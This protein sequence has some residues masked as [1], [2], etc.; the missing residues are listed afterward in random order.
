MRRSGL[1]LLLVAMAAV[2]PAA[3]AQQGAVASA[4]I[5]LSL[6][7]AMLRVDSSSEAIGIARAAVR[8]AEAGRIRARSAWL[9]QLSGSAGYTRTIKSQF[10]GLT[11]AGADSIPGPTNC[12]RFRPNPSLP[13]AERLDSLERGL[14]CAA[15]SGGSAFANLPFGRKNQWSFALSASQTLFNPQLPDG[16]TPQVR[17]W[18][19]PRWRW[20]PSG[21]RRWWKW[22]R[23]TSTPS[24]PTSC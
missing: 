15:N 16:S 6:G 8:S 2:V 1:G 4:P 7:E 19:G 18:T 22:P 24:S 20:T 3:A 10:S 23:P 13:L 9:P 14:D 11:S 5:R 17:R 21:R 12:G